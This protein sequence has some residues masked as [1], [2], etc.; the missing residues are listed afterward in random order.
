[1]EQFKIGQTYKTRSACDADCILA[2]TIESRTAKT[3]KLPN[4][5][6][7]RV[8]EFDGVECFRP[9]GSYSMAPIIRAA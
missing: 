8:F 6:K 9:W 5:K 2:V 4:G 3:V 7:F 1:M